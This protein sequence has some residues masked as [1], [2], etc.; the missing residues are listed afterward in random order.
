M[1]AF[2]GQIIDR[3]GSGDAFLSVTAPCMAKNT[4]LEVVGFVGNVAGA[5]L[6]PRWPT[7]LLSNANL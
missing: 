1:P 7:A 2:A 3:V 6:S 5:R 4:P